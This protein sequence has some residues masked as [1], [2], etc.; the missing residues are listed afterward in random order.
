VLI[1]L[2]FGSKYSVVQDVNAATIKDRQ[3]ST[4]HTI[5]LKLPICIT[6]REL[7]APHILP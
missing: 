4:P 2:A 5:D 1:P 3:A 7:C 6:D